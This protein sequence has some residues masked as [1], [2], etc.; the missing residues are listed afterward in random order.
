MSAVTGDQPRQKWRELEKQNNLVNTLDRV[1]YWLV[2]LGA[3]A[4]SAVLLWIGVQIAISA[5]PAIRTFGLQFLVTTT[6]DPVRNIYGALPQIYGTIVTSIIALVIAIPVGVGV[7]VFLSEDFIPNS[8]RTPIALAIE[9]IAAIPSVV[10]GLWGIFVFIPFIRPFYDFLHNNFGWIPLFSTAPRGN[11]L[12]TLGIVLAV[13]ISPTIIAI[14]RGSLIALPRDLRQ[15]A[16]ALGATRW[17]TI[18]R[19]LIPAAF[20]GIVGSIMLALG[21]AMG[22]TMAAAML[23]GNSN[24]ITT[25]LLAPGATIASIIAAQFGEAGR[26]QVAALL[27]SGLILMIL[28]LIVNILAEIIIQK[29]QNIE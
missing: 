3:V 14:S 15:G 17:E 22:E 6:W 13:M 29:F 16:L 11:S 10:V 25:S 24:Q 9:L 19:V 4:I 2:I 7:A 21:R 8:I 18:L 26:D 20:S 27:Y 28:T 5:L 23:V 12:L 1:F